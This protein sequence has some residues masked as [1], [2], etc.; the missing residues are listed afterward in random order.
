MP[1]FIHP[2]RLSRLPQAR[3]IAVATIVSGVL[4]AG[5]GGSSGN[6]TSAS[7]VASAGSA[8]TARSTTAAAGSATSSVPTAP[9]D[10]ASAALAFA[11]CMRA[12]GVPNFPDP[13]PGGGFVFNANGINP[14]APAVSAAQA[15]CHNLMSGGPPGPGSK[16]HASAQTLAKL[17]AIAQCMRS[18]GVPQFPDPRT[19]V[20]LQPFGSGGGVITDYDGA[21]LLFPSTLNMYSPAYT[22]AVSACGILAGK[23][24]RGP[25]S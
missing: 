25:H 7:T 10:P 1:G 20:P 13:Q 14:S 23:L 11:R 17:L 24:G 22:Q 6:P 18:H 21:I 5:C 12:N 2:N 3:L 4:V 16:T 19:S 9:A 8:T 15:K